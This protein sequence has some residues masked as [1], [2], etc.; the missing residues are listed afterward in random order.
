MSAIII[1][2]LK[3]E[4]PQIFGDGTKRRDF[5]YVDDVNRF[6]EMIINDSRTF[7]QTY[8][9][10][11][12]KNYSVNEIFEII[13]SLLQ[14]GI[15]PDYGDDLLGEAFQNMADITRATQLGWSP[16]IGIKEGVKRSI[17]Y[18]RTVVM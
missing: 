13:E 14:T 16:D 18:I 9:L 11:S 10:G 12:G 5:I 4:I 6:H 3:K 7:G 8:N 2:L 17:D 1:K 15:K